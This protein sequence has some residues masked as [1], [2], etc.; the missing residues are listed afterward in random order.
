LNYE[1]LQKLLKEEEKEERF[2][3]LPFQWLEVSTAVLDKLPLNILREFH[4]HC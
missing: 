2:S 3:A 1:V 4:T